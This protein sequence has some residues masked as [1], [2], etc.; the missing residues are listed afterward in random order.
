L[1]ILG[2]L[3]LSVPTFQCVFEVYYDIFRANAFV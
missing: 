2:L 1:N 3:V